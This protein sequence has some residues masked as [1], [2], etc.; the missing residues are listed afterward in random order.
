MLDHGVQ[1]LHELWLIIFFL[2]FLFVYLRF[3]T[4][5]VNICEAAV[6]LDASFGSYA[7]EDFRGA[8]LAV[9][10]QRRLPIYILCYLRRAADI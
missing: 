3:A 9:R 10:P 2:F 5:T 7:R 4:G 8:L 6:T 1:L